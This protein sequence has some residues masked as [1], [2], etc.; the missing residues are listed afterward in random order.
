VLLITLP[1]LEQGIINKV[2]AANTSAGGIHR[3]YNR[4]R[5]AWADVQRPGRVYAIQP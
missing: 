4:N 3:A 2:I 1:G 5:F